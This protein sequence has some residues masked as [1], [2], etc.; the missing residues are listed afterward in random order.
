MWL[1][2]LAWRNFCYRSLS[3]VLTTISLALG[4]AL[5]VMVLAIVGIVGEAFSRNA[6]VGYNLVV[7]PKGSALQLTLN[8]VYY[9]SQPIENLPYT[10]YMEFFDQPTRA[11]MVRRFGGD[12]ALGERDGTYAPYVAGGYAIPLALGDYLGDFRVVGTTPDFFEKLRHGPTLEEP[13]E[14]RAGR[15]L[16]TFSKEH[17]YY[18]AVLGSRVARQMNLGVGDSFTST[19]GDPEGKGHGQGFAIVGIMGP[20]GTPND[21][22][23]FVNLEGFYLQENH[24]KPLKGDEIIEPPTEAPTSP[25]GKMPLTIP[26]R[27]VTS[28]L[29]RNGNLMFAPGMQNQINESM[30]AQAAAPV[31][32]IAKLMEAIIGPMLAALL[33]I[34][35]VTCVVAAVGVL[36]AIYNSMNDR[37]RDIA[38]MRALGAR[39]ETVTGVILLESLLIAVIGA[40]AGWFLA[41]ASIWFFSGEIE[42]RTGVQ[43]G[44]LT[45]SAYEAYIFPLVLILALLAGFLPAW[46]AYRTD[47]GSNLSA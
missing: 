23:A 13:F 33:V 24:S 27:E 36:V 25:D 10:E 21:R 18:E 30:Q 28:I 29:V 7:G 5:V 47:V 4:V 3:S 45:T 43:V 20:T 34:T 44:I 41:H 31:G 9:L 26:E 38:V 46:S 42:E 11:E 2:R 22:A 1:L 14:F 17:G 15:A 39:R 6:Q 19:H 40:C 37:R 12:P 32:E 8:S 35:L 16:Q